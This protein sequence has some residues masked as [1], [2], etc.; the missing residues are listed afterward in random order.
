M[1]K[2]YC[3]LFLFLTGWLSIIHSQAQETLN[4]L[5]QSGGTDSYELS[6]VST[7]KAD[8]EKQ[9]I[10][11]SYAA[12]EA[13]VVN[14]YDIGSQITWGDGVTNDQKE[15]ILDIIGGLINVD[16][17]TFMMGAQSVDNTQP[18]YD[19]W[20]DAAEGPVHQVK[21]TSFLLNKFLITRKQWI[22]IMGTDHSYNKDNDSIPEHGLCWN[23]AS[24]FVN[25]LN[26]MTGLKFHLPTEAQ[27]EFAA[28]GGKMGR[29]YIYSGSNYASEVGWTNSN[30][31]IRAHSVGQ[32]K[33]NELGFYDMTGDMFEWCEDWYGSYESG[34]VNN[35]T[36]T[37]SGSEKVARGGAY[38]L[39]STIARN[40]YRVSYPPFENMYMGTYTI[41][42]GVRVAL[43][44]TE[45]HILELERT[46]W[47]SEG[48]NDT[49]YVGV[50]TKDETSVSWDASWL[51]CQMIDGRLCIILSANYTG[52]SRSTVVTIKT[53]YFE[54]TITITQ[55]NYITVTP[56]LPSNE[57][58]IGL[59]KW[60]PT[61]TDAQKDVITKLVNNLVCVNGG[62]FNMGAQSTSANGINYNP[63]ATD[64][65]GPVH[66]VNLASFYIDKYEITRNDW[67]TIMGSDKASFNSS[68][69]LPEDGISWGEA[70]NFIDKVNMLSKLSFAMPTEAQWEFAAKGGTY[71]HNYMYAG[72]N[73]AT[74][75]GWVAS[76]SNATTHDIGQKNPNELGLYDMTGNLAEWCVDWFNTYTSIDG[77]WNPTESSYGKEKVA[78][79]G[80]YLL[81]GIYAS[82]TYRLAYDSTV[83]KIYND[84]GS[85]TY[86]IPT[87]LRLAMN[88]AETLNI[89]LLSTQDT[90]TVDI[91]DNNQY[92]NIVMPRGLDWC[93]AIV[94]NGKM[95][96]YVQP[97]YSEN[98]RTMQFV[99]NTFTKNLI[100]NVKQKNRAVDLTDIIPD[101]ILRVLGDT[102]ITIY[103]GF[104]PP[105]VE[106]T[107]VMSPMVLQK[108]SILNDNI[109]A[110][111]N[112]L[113]IK[114]SNQTSSNTL[115]YNSKESSSNSEG[116]GVFITGY[117][118]NFSAFFNTTGHY[119][120]GVTFYKEAIIVSGTKTES[121][122][123]NMI[124]T[125]VM[126][127][128]V[129]PNNKI[130]P[131]GTYRSFH[132]SDGLS[133]IS[134][135][136]WTS[137][138]KAN[139][140]EN[141]TSTLRMSNEI[142]K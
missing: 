89:Q 52:L 80:A 14:P 61:V 78:R 133:V 79:G 103:K 26:E 15:A 82:N 30:S 11:I 31:G 18:N 86:T 129:D 41:P 137:S 68:E 88:Y 114:F 16:G 39:D 128:K 25:K 44:Y 126:V 99:V 122:I 105:N 120:D 57:T 27:W 141:N 116:K 23:D 104:N 117:D 24:T 97:N 42:A 74:D 108:S 33:P 3:I 13:T 12:N 58:I 28:R 8:K 60:D 29:G 69:N 113:F 93:S 4:V 66:K 90:L 95:S 67:I 72:S 17:G 36:G 70:R 127:D 134:T 111:Y 131:I 81:N 40:S 76:N 136:T 22:A 38:M 2:S 48:S 77:I 32:K 56:Y 135:E 46:E 62:Q 132:D 20:A 142:N 45:K 6:K 125:F 54:K 112:D 119:N 51:K 75:V 87:G 37:V 139:R 64:A 34:A 7:L 83:T 10:L 98:E 84:A 50:T 106:G 115:D 85:Y 59:I 49:I 35:P 5:K 109:G 63:T 92:S 124:Y 118:K 91:G 101:S 19:K 140:K 100:V 55:K 71:S 1:K 53:L 65:E 94:N 96:V 121:G 107:Y 102:V 110:Q 138:V 47:I 9:Y 73:D 21:L 123:Q 130:V 43:D